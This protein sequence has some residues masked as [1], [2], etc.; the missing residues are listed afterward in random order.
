MRSMLAAALAALTLGLGLTAS[1]AQT[2]PDRPIKMIVPYG[3]GGV[4]VQ[5]RLAGPFMANLLG[6]PI[7]VENKPGGGA[8]LGTTFVR[9]SPPDG[10]TLLY[11]GTAALS[12]AP[13]MRKVPYKMDDFVP[14]G[15]VTGT[16]LVLVARA[17]APFK[18]VAELVAYAKAN[19]TKVNMGSSGVGTTTHMV[20]EALQLAAGIKFTHVPH[21]GLAQVVAAMLSQSVDLVIG[22]PGSFLPQIQAGRLRA[23]A[24]TGT[25]RSEFLPDVPSLKELGF[26]VVEETKFGLLAPKGVAPEI[27][28]RLSSAL[29]AAVQSK[30]FV[31]KMRSNYVTAHHMNPKDFAEALRQEDTYWG[32]MLAK[33]EFRALKEN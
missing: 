12:V 29:Q 6:Q 33:P 26:D 10:Y 15:N 30:E 9:N 2:F 25:K 24:T 19:P 7:V 21:T 13:H 31:E 8:I 4:D 14:I 1:H 22:I 17:D 11:T 27:V 18:S 23:L 20:G 32:A 5:M 3:P 16:A 28:E